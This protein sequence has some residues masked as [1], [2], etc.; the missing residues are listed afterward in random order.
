MITIFTPLFADEADTNAQNLTA[1][2]VVARLDPDRAA[3]TM[4]HDGAVDARI[5]SRPNTTL[6]RWRRHGNTLR[7]AL[8]ILRRV[9]D[10]YFFPREGPLDAALLRMRRYFHWHTAVVTPVISGGLSTQS[11]LPARIRNIREADSVFA[12]NGYLAQLVREGLGINP[13][14]IHDGIDSRYFF[15]SE[16][17]RIPREPVTVL[18]AGSLRPYKRVPVVVRQAARWPGVK[19]R[20]AGTGEEEQLCKNLTVELKCTN[21]EFLGHL[22]QP[23]L[24]REMRDADIFLFPSV[25]EGHPQVLGQ[26]AASGLSVVAMEI[27][28]PD[29]VVNGTTGFLV[30]NDDELAEKL[31]LLIRDPQLRISMGLAAIAHAQKFDWDI[32]AAKW[33]Q[34]FEE[35]AAKR[36]KH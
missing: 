18:Y 21:V 14:T 13:G 3:V 16:P 2:E 29:Y 27:Y 17:G 35:A 26:A 32:I 19:F 22:S 6:L 36:R 10:V 9:P 4:L 8:H 5:A 30:E 1:K 28:R 7:T 24:G 12:N 34:A 11:Y 20:V 25:I 33:Q 15:P 31:D 23:Q